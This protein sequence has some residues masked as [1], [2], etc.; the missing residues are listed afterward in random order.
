MQIHKYILN[1]IDSM[2]PY[3]RDL[4]IEMLIDL[5]EESKKKR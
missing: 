3:E 1:D 4:Y 5:I 2:I